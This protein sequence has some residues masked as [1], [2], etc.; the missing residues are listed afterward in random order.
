MSKTPQ[1]LVQVQSW[2]VQQLAALGG[3]AYLA[4]VDVGR[5]AVGGKVGYGLRVHAKPNA[6]AWLQKLQLP[7]LLETPYGNFYV[8]VVAVQGGGAQEASAPPPQKAGDDASKGWDVKYSGTE[9]EGAPTKLYGSDIENMPVKVS[10]TAGVK[11]KP[12]QQSSDKEFRIKS[13]A[14]GTTFG[15]FEP[16]DD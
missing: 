5:V 4:G 13:G 10:G 14:F 11:P 12:R 9:I 7:G 8:A 15:Q 6:G 3:S 2:L 1:A 16:Q